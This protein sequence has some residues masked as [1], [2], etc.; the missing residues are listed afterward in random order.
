M[1]YQQCLF[2][3]F[4]LNEYILET[5]ETILSLIYVY[6]RGAFTHLQ[7]LEI[8]HI[9]I[10]EHA[11]PITPHTNGEP[12]LN[13]APHIH[14]LSQSAMILLVEWYGSA[15]TS[16]ACSKVNLLNNDTYRIDQKRKKG[17]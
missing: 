13:G 7:I 6:N 15:L 4:I 11:M 9:C 17:F 14:I 3:P 1:Y 16:K 12:L 5:R 10:L 2:T 8:G